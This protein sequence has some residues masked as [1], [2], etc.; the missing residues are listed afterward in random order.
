[1]TAPLSVTVQPTPN[2][3]ALKFVVNRRVTEGRSRTFTDAATASVPLAKELLGIA[4]VR[5]VFFLNDFIT[6]T[7]TEGTDWDA[8]VPRAESLIRRHLA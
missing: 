4:G 6:V 5:Q 8:V 2:V 7:R 3:N 1:V